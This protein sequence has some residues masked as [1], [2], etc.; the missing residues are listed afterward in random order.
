LYGSVPAGISNPIKR[1]EIS[2]DTVL[3]S[4][5]VFFLILISFGDASEVKGEIPFLES[6]LSSIQS[7]I[8]FLFF[9]N[10]AG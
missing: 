3:E 1:F 10:L 9:R 8:D 5:N 2:L 7:L 4:V 6:L